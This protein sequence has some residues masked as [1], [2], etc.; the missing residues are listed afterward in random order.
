MFE[1]NI[2]GKSTVIARFSTASGVRM[3]RPSRVQIQETLKAKMMVRP[4]PATTP[5][6]PPSGRNPM[7]RLRVSTTTAARM[8]RTASPSSRPTIGAGRQIG[9]ERKRSKT[10]FL[11]SLFSPMPAYIVMKT[12]VWTRM[13]GASTWMYSVGEPSSAPPNR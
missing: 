10:P 12:T 1:A 11:M 5:T 6:T 8:N 2:S 9:N 4:I 13:P 3:T 7:I